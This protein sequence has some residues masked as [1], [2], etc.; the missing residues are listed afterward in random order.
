LRILSIFVFVHFFVVS[1][2]LTSVRGTSEN[3]HQRTPKPA[4]NPAS[5]RYPYWHPPRKNLSGP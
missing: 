3:R 5:P 2:L 1:L 4:Q